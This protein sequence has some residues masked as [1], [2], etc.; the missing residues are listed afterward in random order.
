MVGDAEIGDYRGNTVISDTLAMLRK[1]AARKAKVSINIKFK[2]IV[3][4]DEKS[5]VKIAGFYSSDIN[6]P[7]TK[8]EQSFS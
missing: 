5:K 4:T 1:S 8:K 3:V 2:G 7:C 6:A